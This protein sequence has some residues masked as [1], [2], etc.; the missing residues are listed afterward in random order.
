MGMHVVIVGNPVDGVEIFG[1]FKTGDE[2]TEWGDSHADVGKYRDWWVVPLTAP[3][4]V[5]S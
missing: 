2:A 3:D 1:P 4:V 5:P